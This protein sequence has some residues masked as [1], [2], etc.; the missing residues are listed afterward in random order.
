MSK[1][2]GFRVAA[3]SLLLSLAALATAH[4]APSILD[5]QAPA[6]CPQASSMRTKVEDLL[7]QPLDTHRRQFLHFLGQVRVEGTGEYQ[8]TI[9]AEGPDGTRERTLHQRDCG[10]LSDAAALIVALA[11]DPTLTLLGQGQA[12]PGTGSTD[13]GHRYPAI[14]AN[15]QTHARLLVQAGARLN[16]SLGMLPGIGLGAGLELGLIFPASIRI[17]AI[18]G[19]WAESHVAVPERAGA[20]VEFD[21]WSLG[22]RGC[23]LPIMH[24]RLVIGACAGVDGS[25]MTGSGKNL[26]TPRRATDW[27]WGALGGGRAQYNLVVQGENAL[28]LTLGLEGGPALVRPRFGLTGGETIYQPA[29]WVVQSHLG[30]NTSF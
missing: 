11:I 23:W 17:S 28:S 19:K 8:V 15:S 29:P 27:W 26:D 2:L 25:R 3:R 10:N 22:L 12:S 6:E 21:T 9:V 5:W 14:A 13:R 4:A 18:G 1:Q 24:H 30:I 16:T 20:S 7:G